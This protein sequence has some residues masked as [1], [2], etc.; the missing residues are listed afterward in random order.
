[1]EM[2]QRDETYTVGSSG[3]NP[4]PNRDQRHHRRDE[5]DL[6]VEEQSDRCRQS[7]E[8]MSL[9]RSGESGE[10]H[11][12]SN[13][14]TFWPLPVRRISMYT[15]EDNEEMIFIARLS[16]DSIFRLLLPFE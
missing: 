9:R 6:H 14:G 11:R 15:F 3:S 2:K 5:G 4:L 12:D 10:G 13:R 1:M 16:R 7:P 8:H